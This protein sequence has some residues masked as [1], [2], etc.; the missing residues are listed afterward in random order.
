MVNMDSRLSIKYVYMG[1][2]LDAAVSESR[3]P[4]TVQSRGKEWTGN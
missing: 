1:E 3:R 4:A 2:A